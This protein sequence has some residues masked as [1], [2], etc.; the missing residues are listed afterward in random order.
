MYWRHHQN[1]NSDI[2]V[3]CFIKIKKMSHFLYILHSKVANIYY[4]GETHDLKE[5]ASKHNNHSYQN[6]FTKIANDWE[7]ALTF[8]CI[9]R[10]DALYL[11][12][13]IKK[14]KSKIFIEKIILNPEI[15]NDILSKK[16]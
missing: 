3:F 14:M 7:L 4:T 8:E 12:S 1:P 2:R 11:E 15:L 16:K 6:S 9:D 5:R 13:F 10:S